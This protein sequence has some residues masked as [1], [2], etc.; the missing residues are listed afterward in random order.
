MS[1]VARIALTALQAFDTLT[2]VT[3]NNIVNAGTEGYR[4]Q[5]VRLEETSRPGV[6]ATVEEPAPAKDRVTIGGA[7]NEVSDV[8]LEEEIVALIGNRHAYTA[9]TKIIQAAD[10]MDGKL[11]SILA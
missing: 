4:K 11:L 1:D 9:S 10:A 2:K 5:S 6:K 7:E 8:R 3:A